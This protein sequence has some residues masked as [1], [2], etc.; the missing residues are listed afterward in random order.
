M[1]LINK[2]EIYDYDSDYEDSNILIEC[3][4]EILEIYNIDSKKIEM[5]FDIYLSNE[6]ICYEYREILKKY[7]MIGE[8]SINNQQVLHH[9]NTG[10]IFCNIDTKKIIISNIEKIFIF[11]DSLQEVIQLFNNYEKSCSLD[12]DNNEIFIEQQ[13][14]FINLIIFNGDFNMNTLNYNFNLSKKILK[15]YWNKKYTYFNQYHITN[16]NH[17]FIDSLQKSNNTY[18]YNI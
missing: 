5:N 9:K 3:K 6:K 12:E 18:N 10:F 2:I 15:K 17:E 1:K 7:K 4:E 14:N 16:F 8:C 11:I 13:F